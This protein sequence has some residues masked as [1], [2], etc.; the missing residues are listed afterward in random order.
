MIKVI[1]ILIEAIAILHRILYFLF[2]TM[3]KQW[4]DFDALSYLSF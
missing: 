3:V 4:F 1:A 2:L